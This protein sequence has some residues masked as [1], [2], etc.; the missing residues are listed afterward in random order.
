MFAIVPR[1]A[2]TITHE[3]TLSRKFFKRQEF[4]PNNTIQ[5]KN[6]FDT[7]LARYMFYGLQ[8]ILKI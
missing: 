1:S 5:S 6:Y 8:L 4:D 2:S 3:I 7:L